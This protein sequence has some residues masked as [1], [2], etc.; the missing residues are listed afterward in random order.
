MKLLFRFLLLMLILPG[1]GYGQK[2][3]GRFLSDTLEVGRNIKFALSLTH[4][5]KHPVT[6]PDSTHNYKPFE[7]IEIEYFPTQTLGGVSLDSAVY[8]LLSFSTD[9]ILSLSLPVNYLKTGKNQ[10]S[11]KE[12]VRLHSAISQ[13]T[14]SGYQLEASTGFFEV[15]I[16][17]NYPKILY[18][19]GLLI[20]ISAVIWLIFGKFFIRTYKI[21]RYKNK[22]RGFLSIYKRLGRNIENQKIVSEVLLV[23]KKHMAWLIRKPIESMSTK[24]ISETI[25]NDRLTEALKEFDLAIYGGKIS[26]HL[27]I[28][29]IIMQ[30][31]ATEAF[32]SGFKSYKTKLK[33]S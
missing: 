11:D 31:A 23:W 17:F 20:A 28:A 2:P 22:H 8:T 15:P 32:K 4:N 29:M 26:S 30:D 9:S 14:I 1:L 27:S 24:E 18:F 16:D 21:W 7:L 10:F 13:K 6:F 25:P 12:F 33:S 5:S 3:K 19:L